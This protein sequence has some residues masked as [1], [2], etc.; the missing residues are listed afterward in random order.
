[1]EER[2][3][4][5]DEEKEVRRPV[6]GPVFMALDIWVQANHD[7]NGRVYGFGSKNS[8][9]KC[10]ARLLVSTRSSSVENYDAG[11]MAMRFNESVSNQVERK[12]REALLKKVDYLADVGKKDEGKMKMMWDFIKHHT[13]GPSNEPP[14]HI[15]SS[16]DD[17]DGDGAPPDGD[18]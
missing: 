4:V 8:K 7:S 13:S 2:E 5:T 12:S 6:H 1:M 10:M 9:P 14:P 18:D 17:D 15:L 16:D 11:K 3:E